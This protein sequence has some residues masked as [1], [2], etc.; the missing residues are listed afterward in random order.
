M[1]RALNR[2][3]VLGLGLALMGVGLAGP[4]RALTI[5]RVT[6]PGGIEAW[7][8]RDHT[9]P[10]IAVDI[11][12]RGGASLDPEGKEGLSHLLASTMD[13]GAGDLDSK[14]FQQ[15]LV[16]LS[17]SLKFNSS[18]DRFSGNLTM[19]TEDRDTAFGLLALALS[20]PRF[21][22]EPVN[23]IRA[24]IL[25]GLKAERTNP[26]DI[27]GR[28]MMHLLF[29]DHPYGRPSKGRLETL[30]GVTADDLRA[31]LH[32]H[33]TKD[34]LVVGVVGDITPEQ[35]KPL[36]DKTFG[37]L[38]EK[39]ANGDVAQVTAQDDGKIHLT[40][41]DVPQST[42][43][44]GHRGITRDH[45]DFYAGII[46]NYVLGGGSFA[47][48]LYGEVRE[49]RGLAYSVYSYLYPLDRAGLIA[50]GAGTANER[51]SETVQVVRDEWRRIAETGIN[52]EEL[53][54]AKTYLTGSYPLRFTS[55]ERIAGILAAV[56]M[57]RLGID[58][59]NQRNA[60]IDAVTLE[61]VNKVARDLYRPD[62][63]T[64]FVVGKPEGLESQDVITHQ[65]DM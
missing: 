62:R 53:A 35:L 29:P 6:S 25:A 49:K 58:Y 63:L 39:S 14:A 61:Q 24:Q 36:L 46:L 31:Y 8:V 9:N 11:M 44:F 55:S 30:P 51:V 7:L 32:R 10:I 40:E 15:K 17:I 18:R 20:K 27:A 59:I 41:L 22:A 21:D 3:L 42:I 45:P 65:P 52:E 19:L 1:G 64:F 28:S 48:R 60:L 37:D 38:P 5:D 12:F 4:A 26:D 54:N 23:R 33:L 34:T 2:L 43:L 50:G 56:Q 16:D 47:S 13:E 57:E